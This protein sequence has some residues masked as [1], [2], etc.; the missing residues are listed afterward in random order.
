[1]TKTEVEKVIEY[2][3]FY[4]GD[5]NCDAHIK[6]KFCSIRQELE[7]MVEAGSYCE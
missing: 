4:Y 3:E 5:C 1:M 6:C 2:I 7:E